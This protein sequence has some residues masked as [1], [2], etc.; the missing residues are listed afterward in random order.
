MIHAA[1][2]AVALS[3]S[4]ITIHSEHTASIDEV[5]VVD[6]AGGSITDYVHEVAAAFAE[7]DARPNI[8]LL[9]GTDEVKISPVSIRV[10]RASDA[11]AA[12]AGH[13]Y[14]LDDGTTVMINF[15][16]VGSEES[17]L[18]V[19]GIPQYEHGSHRNSSARASRS[20]RRLTAI[21]DRQ[22]AILRVD[23]DRLV[24][25]HDVAR[26]VLKF[27]GLLAESTILPMPEHGLM[28]VSTT[29]EGRSLVEQV[30][31]EVAT[32]KERTTK[33]KE[34]VTETREAS[35]EARSD[36]RSEIEAELK[37]I[38]RLRSDDRL[39]AEERQRNSKRFAELLQEIR[40]IP[41]S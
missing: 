33:P 4:P 38:A 1:I 7:S 13:D 24:A 36:R 10:V 39:G 27:A 16:E 28:L 18:R 26:T 3:C 30:I 5:T 14:L 15:E 23:H 34:S 37:R 25:T 8:V 6:F 35:T 2:T 12:I 41:R 40:R 29:E 19:S 31:F 9:P 22:V 32:R 11:L 21:D 17:I 20:G